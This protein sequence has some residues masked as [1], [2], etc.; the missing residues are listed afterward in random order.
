MFSQRIFNLIARTSVMFRISNTLRTRSRLSI[1][2]NYRSTQTRCYTSPIAKFFETINEQI[3]KNKELQHN[4]KLLQDQAGQL[5]ESDTLRKAKEVYTK[6]KEGA[7]NTTTLGSE[8]LKKSMDEI[9]KSVEKVGSVVSNRIEKVNETPFVKGSKEKISQ[10]S[11]KV[12]TTTEPIRQTRVYTNIRDSLKETVG[13]DSMRYGGFIDKETRRKMKEEAIKSKKAGSRLY[14][15]NPDQNRAGS[16]IVL[17]KDSVWKESW[18][19]LKETNPIIQGI[20]SMKRNYEDSDNVLISY[21]RAFTDRVSDALGSF[22]EENETAQAITQIKMMDPRFNIE[23]FMKEA[24]EYIIPEIMEAYLK[25]DTNT[26][27][28]W[29]S[30]A[31][32]NVLTHGIK[33]QIQQD[34]ISDSRILDIRD[35]EFVAAKILENVD[36]PVLVLSFN[37]QEV[38]V[39]RDRKTNEIKFGSEDQIDQNTY[40]CVITKQEDRLTDPITN[41]WRIIDMAKSSSQKL[42]W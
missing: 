33:A 34:L 19:R 9:K 26:L 41:G 18:N 8:K 21:T 10:F 15:S 38:I 23:E 14:N 40:G 1:Q 20:F 29:C 27:R 39:F 28:E 32:Y 11:D 12:S 35:V 25:G 5:G 17:H 13:D 36:I 31:T 22:F 30:E 16:S 24:R 6:A 4:V 7:E 37:T 42:L 2:Q 3:K